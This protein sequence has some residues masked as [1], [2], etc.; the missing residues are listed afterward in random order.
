MKRVEGSR[1]KPAAWDQE[2]RSPVIDV[3][4]HFVSPGYIEHARRAIEGLPS[5]VAQT[6]TSVRQP[7]PALTSLTARVAEMDAAKVDVSVLSLPPPGVTVGDL[8]ERTSMA[9]LANDECL[10][11]A[12]GHPGRFAVL[13]A[14]PFPDVGASLAELN[15]VGAHPL[16]RGINLQT[17][18]AEGWTIDDAA[19]DPI[20]KRAAELGLPILVH[21]AIEPLADAWEEFRLGAS[22]APVVSSSLSVAR[23]L[24]SGTLDRISDLQLIVPHL[25]GVLPYLTQR[26][27]DFDPGAAEH[28]LGW[29]LAER[30][31]LDTCSYHPPALRCAIET[32]GAERLVMGTDYPIRGPLQRAVDHIRSVVA[33]EADQSSI[34]GGTAARW[35]VAT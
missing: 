20:Y 9:V 18:T 32:C 7:S 15:R 25:G 29:Y 11:A 33:D 14:L 16:A 35:F 21:P 4:S 2:S 23:M 30:L 1:Y 26:F 13:V 6:L 34:L 8:D 5:R 3:H 24:L 17:M 12:A 31:Y 22:L 28:N 27:G 19:F 10:D